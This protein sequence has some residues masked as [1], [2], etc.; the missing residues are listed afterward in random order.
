MGTKRKQ[1][2]AK[3]LSGE[4]PV[5]DRSS[6]SKLIPKKLTAE[7]IELEEA[8]FGQAVVDK[9]KQKQNSLDAELDTA[10]TKVHIDGTHREL[11]EVEDNDLFIIDEGEKPSSSLGVLPIAPSIPSESAPRH[12]VKSVPSSR[13]PL[14]QDSSIAM[15]SVSL[16]NGPNRLKKLRQA[17]DLDG[18][19]SARAE[20]TI[21]GEEYEIRLRQQFEKMNPIPGWLKKRKRKHTEGGQL[22]PDRS[23]S[24]SDSGGIDQLL[25]TTGKIGRV[26]GGQYRLGATLPQGEL[27][28]E[29]LRDANQ[30]IPSTNK[31]TISA[32]QFHP[33]AP[34]LFTASPKSK[35]L[36]FFK[37]DGKH[38]PI[39]HH[40]HTPDLPITTAEFCP[41][42][43]ES[44][45]VLMTGNRP[46]FYAFN[47]VTCQCIKS[48][49]S[50][51]TKS[52]LSQSIKG[53][54]LSRFS[55]SPQ[56]QIVAFLGLRGLIQLVDWSNNIGSSQVIGSLKSNTPIK[57][58]SWNKN[59]T[60][61]ITIGNN[62]EVSVWDMRM[63]KLLTSWTD[64][65]GF[66]PTLITTTDKD[67][68]KAT[69]RSY[70]AIGS[71]TG[72]VNVYDDSQWANDKY[73]ES[74]V[75]GAERKPM[76]TIENLTTT[77][78]T[79]KFN[80]DAQILAI[81]S[82]ARKDQLKLVHLPSATVFS[83]WPT[84]GTPL[85]HV[86]DV[87][88]SNKSDMLAIANTKGTVLLYSLGWWSKRGKTNL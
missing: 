79:M 30:A 20:G 19:G 5:A 85:G 12:Q 21:D 13:Q 73:E 50:L 66:N 57:S 48:P 15:V 32:I 71:Q 31:N 28:V 55:F 24:D 29:R 77:V 39:L 76:K 80:P 36:S 58:L 68:G 74:R 47:L 23:D 64:H 86:S 35:T 46:Y 84:S 81:A 25:R 37:I 33:N 69:A 59:G 62:A 44:S 9:G 83:N 53:T 70:T 4:P 38:N 10:E 61:L 82:D 67:G 34:I 45:T 1:K 26:K 27:Q 43:Q 56:G 41:S 40:V 42:T 16:T 88:F 78:T 87:G 72:I 14:W 3:V 22:N 11:A 75:F 2:R 63:R 18:V 7:E 17:A 6:E 52:A 54:S 60:E 65:G 49:D 51:F 8:V